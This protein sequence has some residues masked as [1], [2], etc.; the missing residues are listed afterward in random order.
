MRDLAVIVEREFWERVRSKSFIISTILTPIF[1]LGALLLPAFLSQRSEDRG[2]RLVIVDESADRL[3]PAVITRLAEDAGTDTEVTIAPGDLSS[4]SAALTARL[5]SGSIDAYMRIPQDVRGGSEVSLWSVDPITT[6]ERSRIR[7][8]LSASIQSER[9]AELGIGQE[10]VQELLEPVTLNEVRV[11]ER[12]EEDR[13]VAQ[14]F[15]GVAVAF[16][17]YFLILIYG[18]HVLRSAQEEKAN[19]ISE[20]LVSSVSPAKLMLG[21][22]LGVGSTALLQVAI[23]GALVMALIGLPLLAMLGADP[24][25]RNDILGFIPVGGFVIFALFVVLGFFLFATMFAALGAAAETM[26]DAQRFTMP[27][28]LPLLIPIMMAETLVRAPAGTAAVVMSWIPLTAPLVVPIRWFAGGAGTTDVILAVAW[29][30]LSIVAIGWV[31]GRIYRAG[32]LNTGR[33]A[34][35][36]SVAAWVRGR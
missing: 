24:E 7:S 11:T 36:R 3:G 2:F 27:L 18:V 6:G 25:L 9:A 8:A 30:L 15:V 4:Q 14:S 32:I 1:F 13:S 29:L 16:I 17:L 33:R 28:T 12:G 19:R 21:K 31:A 23:W 26:E 22:V 10:S 34:G 20:I 35:W 5:R